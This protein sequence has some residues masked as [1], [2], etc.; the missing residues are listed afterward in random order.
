VPQPVLGEEFRCAGS[1]RSQERTDH[2]KEG[3]HPYD[4]GE[5]PADQRARQ[6]RAQ[7]G[8]EEHDEGVQRHAGTRAAPAA[9]PINSTRAGAVAAIAAMKIRST[10]PKATTWLLSWDAGSAAKPTSV[11]DGVGSHP[12]PAMGCRWPAG[13]GAHVHPVHPLGTKAFKYLRVRNDMRDAADLAAL[14]QMGHLPEAWI[15][16]PAAWE[17]REPVRHR[18]KPRQIC[19]RARARPRPVPVPVLTATLPVQSFMGVLP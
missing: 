3:Y 1:D 6:L 2:E 9:S 18:H 13:T 17:L 16:P 10:T 14:L 7:A 19:S 11:P 12:R 4:P 5:A 15:A 8:T